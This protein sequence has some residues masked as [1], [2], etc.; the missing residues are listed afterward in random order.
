MSSACTQDIFRA[1]RRESVALWAWVLAFLAGWLNGA[2]FLE[3]GQTLSHMTGNLT[4]LGF[5]AT[6]DVK[7]PVMLFALMLIG[8]LAGATLSGF[9]FPQ[10]RMAQWRRCGLVVLCAGVLLLAVELLFAASSA[11]RI[12]VISLVMGAQNGLA[13]RYQGVLARTTHVTGHLTDCAAA[14]GRILH[15]KTWRGTNGK[16]LLFHVMCV[17]LFLLGVVLIG[18]YGP[19]L[20]Q[21]LPVSTVSLAGIVYVLLGVGTLM[22][23]REFRKETSIEN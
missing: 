2:G 21:H 15:Q 10:H 20:E 12:T 16:L 5:A 18:L 9:A 14:L 3:F 7:E 8:F 11:L 22:C 4:K 19:A 1:L 17:V 13:M 23:K 6:G